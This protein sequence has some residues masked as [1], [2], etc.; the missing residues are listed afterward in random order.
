MTF[1][2]PRYSAK[3]EWELLRLCTAPEYLVIGGAEKLFKYAVDT[4]DL[5]DVLDFY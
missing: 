5:K 4:Y 1:G 2:K 3:Q